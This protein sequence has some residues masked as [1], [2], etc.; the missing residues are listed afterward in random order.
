MESVVRNIVDIKDA[1]RWDFDFH[2]PKYLGI[3]TSLD[4]CYPVV[5]FGDII[6]L[7]TDM[8]AFSLYK[9]EFFVDKGVP[10][11]RVQNIQEYGID[12]EKDT[13]YISLDYHQ[14]LKRSQLQANDIL[15]TTK[16]FSR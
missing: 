6:N 9:T 14:Q 2:A 1:R 7:L 5:R 15:L 11:L 16:A 12:L 10:F 4:R 8:G 3:I 13:K